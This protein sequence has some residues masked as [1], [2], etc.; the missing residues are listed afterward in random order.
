MGRLSD[1]S[2]PVEVPHPHRYNLTPSPMSQA[3][4]LLKL[5]RDGKPHSTLEILDTV[6]GSA[7]LGLARV[8]A[9]VYDLKQQGYHIRSF[10]DPRNKAV[11]WYQLLTQLTLFS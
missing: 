1:V 9:R 11:W 3:Q 7:H 4:R 6:Y 2:G 5:L 8:G 10:R